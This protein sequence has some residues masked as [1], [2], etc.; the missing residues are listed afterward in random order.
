MPR[1]AVGWAAFEV[2]GALFF[3]GAAAKIA[4]AIIQRDDA[5]L[6]RAGAV[7]IVMN[8]GFGCIRLLVG[9]LGGVHIDSL[10]KLG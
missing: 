2:L 10:M 8:A 3:L 6:L 5:E 1:W 9:F 7:A 4:K